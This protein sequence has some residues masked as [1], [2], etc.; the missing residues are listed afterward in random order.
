MVNESSK[1]LSRKGTA[2]FLGND[3]IK[4]PPRPLLYYFN[5]LFVIEPVFTAVEEIGF[6]RQ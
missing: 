4:N 1:A 5:A 2:L 6:V 3:V